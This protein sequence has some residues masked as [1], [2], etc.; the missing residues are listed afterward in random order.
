MHCPHCGNDL[1][2]GAS[3]CAF[4]GAT[5]RHVHRSSSCL[6]QLGAFIV[7]WTGVIFLASLVIN[8]GAIGWGIFLGIFGFFVSPVA[9]SVLLRKLLPDR[10]V[11][12]R[13]QS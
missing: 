13:N 7:W 5:K 9:V 6:V 2:D 4:C 1:P 3:A 11:W 10:T 8:A 12:V